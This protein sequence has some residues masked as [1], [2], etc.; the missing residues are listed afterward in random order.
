[1]KNENY[2]DMK[3]LFGEEIELPESLS[4][5]NIVKK[6][7]ES[8]VKQKK[9][10]VKVFPRFVAAAAAFAVVATGAFAV[11]ERS[12]G[13]KRPVTFENATSVAQEKQETASQENENTV[14]YSEIDVGTKKISLSKFK[15]EKDLENYFLNIATKEKNRKLFGNVK[16]NGRSDEEA[17]ENVVDYAPTESAHDQ[18]Q[19]SASITGKNDSSFG[20]TNTQVDGVD[21]ADIIKNDGNYLYVISHDKLSIINAKTMKLASQN[22]FKPT[23][24]GR[25]IFITEIYVNEN[26]LVATGYETEKENDGSRKFNDS[27]AYEGCIGI[28]G[29]LTN[30]VSIVF[31][32]SNRELPKEIRRVRQDGDIVSSR[33]VGTCLYTATACY[34]DTDKKKNFTPKVNSENLSSDDVYVESEKKNTGSYLLLTG[35]DTADEKSEISKVSVISSSSEVYCSKDTFYVSSDEYDEKTDKSVTNIHAFSFADGKVSYKASASIPGSIDDQYMMDQNGEYLR[36]A[37]NDYD[38]K[39]DADVSSLYILDGKMNVIGKL[40]DIAND[41]Q[42][43]SVRFMGNTAYVVTFKNTDPLFAIDLS[44]PNAPKIL[45]SVKL[46]GFSEYLHPLSENLLVGIGYDGDEENADFNKVKI[47][48]FDVSD[49]KNP[50]EVASHVIKNAFCDVNDSPKSFLTIDENT[51]GIPVQYADYNSNGYGSKVIFKTFTV[52]DGEFIEKNNYVHA[53]HG[54]D[55]EFFRGTFIGNYIYTLDGETVK[56]FDMK[57]EKELSALDYVTEKETKEETPVVYDE[58][59]KEVTA[60]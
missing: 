51:F 8:D 22:E 39:K 44:K 52:K 47:S 25:K 4:K 48:L 11:Y 31:D 53:G 55:S 57:S 14:S 35:Y 9:K 12:F 38:Y 28:Y 3:K 56:Q 33:M 20:K 58:T 16:Y 5:E 42:I 17:Y 1:M 41:E 59:I 45:G 23:E 49:K 18:S 7:K 26:R 13:S 54:F 19:S 15:S 2:D 30:S 21:E 60:F 50:K 36:V 34:P 37:T 43:K 32:V 40:E 46:P 24:S 29:K 6:I 27:I 10:R